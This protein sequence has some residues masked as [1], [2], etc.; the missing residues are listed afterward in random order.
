MAAI[1]LLFFLYIYLFSGLLNSAV[2]ISGYMVMVSNGLEGMRKAMV[3]VPGWW[4]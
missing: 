2:G 3:M 4:V 1:E